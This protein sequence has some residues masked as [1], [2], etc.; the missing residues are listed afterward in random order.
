MD[1]RDMD[2]DNPDMDNQDQMKN[3]EV[4]IVNNINSLNYEIMYT[5]K[6]AIRDL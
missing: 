2:M 4:N 6:I 1:N 3:V 5:K